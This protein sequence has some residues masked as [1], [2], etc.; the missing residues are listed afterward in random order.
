MENLTIVRVCF[1]PITVLEA[2]GPCPFVFCRG[3]IRLTHP[4]TSLKSLGPFPS[5]D[6]PAPG[7]DAQTMSFAVLPLALERAA[8]EIKIL[9]KYL[10]PKTF[11]NYCKC[12]C[13]QQE[14]GNIVVRF[15][16]F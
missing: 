1:G 12:G 11:E 16:K 13:D 6:P 4:I 10:V 8:T 3:R 15:V 7:F 14:R 9:S 5:I 2:V